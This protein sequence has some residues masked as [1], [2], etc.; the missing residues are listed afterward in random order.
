M[1]DVLVSM[2]EEQC[3]RRWAAMNNF[4]IV[5]WNTLQALVEIAPD[6]MLMFV[7][8]DATYRLNE[9]QRPE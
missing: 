3:A 9:L 5:D 2:T 6:G 8:V 7:P 4:A 1:T